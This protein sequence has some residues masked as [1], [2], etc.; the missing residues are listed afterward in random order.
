MEDK[1]L[2]NQ[3]IAN[4]IDNLTVLFQKNSVENQEYFIAIQQDIGDLGER[5]TNVE[6]KLTGVETRLTKVETDL[7]SVKTDLTGVKTDLTDV[8]NT[9]ATQVVTKDYLDE[10]LDKFAVPIKTEDKK[11]N[12]LTNKLGARNV[13]PAADV[14]EVLSFEPF[15]KT[16]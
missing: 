3:D 15:P 16:V 2:T 8:K 10:K 1:Q 7:A 4:K 5:M 6:T 14:A 11:I 13:L 12:I 9:I